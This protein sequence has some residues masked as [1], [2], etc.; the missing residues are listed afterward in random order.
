MQ[1]N[2]LG[3]IAWESIWGSY[4][5]YKFND[6]IRDNIWTKPMFACLFRLR[7]GKLWKVNKHQYIAYFYKKSFYTYGG[8]LY[9]QIKILNWLRR[10]KQRNHNKQKRIEKK[11]RHNALRICPTGHKN[12][13]YPS[14]HFVQHFSHLY[15]VCIQVLYAFAHIQESW[16]Q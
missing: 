3:T 6:F 5:I 4:S 10:R 16:Y 8:K 14:L 7:T 13:C 15:F 1:Q 2:P 9:Q 12:Y 11:Q